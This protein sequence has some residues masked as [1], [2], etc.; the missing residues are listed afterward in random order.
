VL[1]GFRSAPQDPATQPA[2]Y[3]EET[4][5]F[6]ALP[7]LWIVGLII[8]PLVVLFAVWSYRGLSRVDKPVRTFLSIVRG[9]AIAACLLALFQPAWEQVRYSAVRTQVHVLVDDSA[10]MSRRDTYPD[11]SQRS[12]LQQQTGGEV[13]QFTRAEL[14]GKV[15]AKQKGLLD[16]L[17]ENHDLRLFKFVRKPTAIGSLD[18]LS[19]RGSRS[20]LG[21]ALDLHLGTTG[22]ANLD[23]VILV[24][25]GRS[26]SGLSPIDVAAKYR[27]NDL[28]IFTVGV[29]D[30]SPPRNVRLSGPPGPREA[31]RLEEVA[32]DA[33]V[34]AEGLEGRAVTVTLFGER[35]GG[36]RQALATAT[37]ALGQDGQPQK[38]RLYHAFDEAG[39]WTLR[40]EVTA[41]PEETTT[42]DNVDVRFLRVSD[43]R[44]RV[45][46]LEGF[47][48][49]EYRYLKNALLRVDASIEVQVYLFDASRDFV[50][51]HSKHLEPL[52][53]LPSS[54][55][56]LAAYH[57]VILGDVLPEQLAP[58]EDRRQEWLSLLSQFVE[59]GGGL[60]VVWGEWAM[61]DR[62]RGTP[63][64]DLLPVVLE[65]PDRVGAVDWSEPFVPELENP[66]LP[67]D[68]VLLKRDPQENATLWHEMLPALVAY[69]P[70]QQAKAGST[71]LLRH[72][73][74]ANRFGKRPILVT[75][76][77]PRGRTLFLATD[78]TWRWRQ[79]YGEKYHDPFWR[80]VVRHLAAGRL[81]R[82]DDRVELRLDRVIIDTGE[83]VRVQLRLLEAELAPRRTPEA[84][85]FFRRAEGQPERRTLQA[86]APGESAEFEGRFTLPDPGVV[87]VLVFENDNPDGELLARED[88]LVKVPDLE[89]ARSSQDR[90]T[91]EQI[92]AASKDGFYSFLADTQRL[93]AVFK[94]RRPTETE[95]DRST[96]PLWDHWWTLAA[97]LFLLTVEWIVRKR[98][99]LV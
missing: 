45:L 21:D 89:L 3:T 84:H 92:A 15:L 99:R 11:Q 14:V 10:S 76:E 90:D 31:L 97:I 65:E 2:V 49:W 26:N 6:L 51:E 60:G 56:E 88:V 64:E 25:D 55:D 33:T 9:L 16:Q 22:A 78:E 87:S 35:Q 23:A 36:A 82:R 62:Y 20:P 41:L 66:T 37:T 34:S 44:I 46:Y 69:Y 67:H 29:G 17:K 18:E 5:R 28:A 39:D 24:S 47:P 57:V 38:V 19:A 98:V 52:R 59:R 1:E 54:K 61:P 12:A 71:V 85:V 94:D 77:V 73:K 75:G 80:N 42:E 13:S 27:S 30:P 53:Q 7:E 68:V 8:V 79:H 50:Q 40:F 32:F 70:V 91:L 74:D 72:P 83:Q 4:F 96:R 81:R 58:T 48:R 95:V 43:Q 93:A 86:T 63:L